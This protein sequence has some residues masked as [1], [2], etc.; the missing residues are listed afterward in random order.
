MANEITKPKR[1]CQRMTE[2][3]RQVFLKVLAETG[4]R[5]AAAAAASPHL[6]GG[7]GDRPGYESFRDLWKRDPEF[8]LKVQRAES[9]ALGRVE[10]EI[11]KR[12]FTL[13]ERPIFDRQGNKIGV[14]TDSRPANQMLLR[15]AE[16]L[17]PGTWAQRKHH[18]IDG[19][20]SHD[21]QHSV[22]VATLEPTDVL[23]L[24]PDEQNELLR[25]V[26]KIAELK[27]GSD[28]PKGVI[29]V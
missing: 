25:L 29:D 27:S 16:R 17:A 24:E 23:L 12:A 13:D 14:Q 4:S 28:K 20:I 26:G 22:S 21:H 3:R 9:Q 11:A 5:S 18:E 1:G 7:D 10:S 6:D 8:A 19:K 15:L 2:E